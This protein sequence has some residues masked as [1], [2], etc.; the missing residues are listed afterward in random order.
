[1]VPGFLM[2]LAWFQNSTHYHH[3]ICSSLSAGLYSRRLNVTAMPASLW[4]DCFTL[5]NQHLPLKYGIWDYI[6]H[7]EKWLPC[8]TTNKQSEWV[9]YCSPI[10]RYHTFCLDL[11]TPLIWILLDVDN[12]IKTW[13][14]VECELQSISRKYVVLC[15]PAINPS[16]VAYSEQLIILR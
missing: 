16:H 8:R 12:F 2:E 6:T 7:A 14:Y 9:V 5:S 15:F 4:G 13:I 10:L 11:M 3:R 1:M